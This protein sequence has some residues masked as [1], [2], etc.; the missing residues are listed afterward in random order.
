[1]GL[2]KYRYGS[3]KLVANH[4]GTRTESQVLSHAQS[5]RAKRKRAEERKKRQTGLAAA[6]TEST[7]AQASK[8][9]NARCHLLTNVTKA[10]AVEV[11]AA[12]TKTVKP[13]TPAEPRSVSHPPLAKTWKLT[14]EK[15]LLASMG[16]PVP[17]TTDASIPNL[18]PAEFRLGLELPFRDESE[19]E[20]TGNFP[21]SATA[22]REVRTNDAEEKEDGKRTENRSTTCDVDP[23][24]PLC[25]PPLEVLLDSVLSDEDLLELL[26]IPSTQVN[27][28][29]AS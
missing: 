1:M 4:V 10:R 14:A 25:S 16:N 20:K 5:I 2:G 6:P 29:P 26:E 21:V 18:T 12:P 24:A 13:A 11:T 15:L 27:A 9:Q 28:S 23:D 3:W 22:C 7:G 8:T 19:A 17:G